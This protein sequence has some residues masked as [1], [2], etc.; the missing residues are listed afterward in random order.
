MS[1]DHVEICIRVCEQTQ[2]VETLHLV[3]SVD[4]RGVS[5]QSWPLSIQTV[6]VTGPF[7]AVIVPG[8]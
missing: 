6:N 7:L 2:F 8:I 1:R 3:I 5:G 4:L